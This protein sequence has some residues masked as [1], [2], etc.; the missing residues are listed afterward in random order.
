VPLGE[1]IPLERRHQRG[2]PPKNRNFTTI[3]WSSVRTVVIDTDLLLIITSTVYGLSG[4]TNIDD[5][6]RPWTP[7]IPGFS[8]FFAILGCDT[9]F[10]SEL[11]RNRF[12]IDQ[13]KLHTKCSALNVYFNG[14][15]FDPLGSTSLPYEGIKF[16]YPVEKNAIS[17]TV[18]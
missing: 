3:G 13:D 8:E 17:A 16:G 11:R 4:G 12:K 9:H 2:V 7:R 5:L 10:N 6:E 14:V 15:G 1:E 18:D